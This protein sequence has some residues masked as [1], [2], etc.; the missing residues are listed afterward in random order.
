VGKK[1]G[2]MESLVADRDF[3]RGRSVFITGH[4]GFKGGWAS[5][6]MSHLGA[7]VHGYSLNGDGDLNF[8]TSTG[9]AKYLAASSFGNICDL[10]TLSTAMAAAHP[11]IVIHMAAQPLV[12]QSYKDPLE[13]FMTNV[14]G[15]ANVFEAARNV[16]SVRAI[17][18]VTTDKCYAVQPIARGYV[19]GDPLGGHDPYS[20]SKACAD[21]VGSAYFRSFLENSGVAVANVRAGNVIGGGD[22]AAERLVPDI[23][24]ASDNNQAVKIRSPDAIRPWQHVLEPI[25]GYLNLA[26]RLCKHGNEFSGAWNFGPLSSDEKTVGWIADRLCHWLDTPT[27]IEEQAVQPHETSVLK[28]DSGKATELLGWRPRWRL[29][30]ALE[31]T[32]QW[33]IAW[34]EQS[35]MDVCSIQQIEAYESR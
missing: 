6:W 15:T 22:W 25:S 16:S 19:E 29:E 21:M 11:S 7:N 20:A 12:R 27:W 1:K 2:A 26:E 32:V 23:F 13:T 30:T 8:Y 24:R 10:R 5:I 28:L 18:N 4:T 3:W 14:M 9:L 31:K 17:I 33:H 35:K 34:K